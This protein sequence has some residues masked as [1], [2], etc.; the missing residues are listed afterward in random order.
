MYIYL[1]IHIW[2]S[3]LKPLKYILSSLTFIVILFEYIFFLISPVYFSCLSPAPHKITAV[4]KTPHASSSSP[5]NNISLHARYAALIDADNNRLLY[6]KG[7]DIKAPNASTT[8]IITLI[9]ALSICADDYIATTSAY[10][11]SMP[12]VQLNAINGEQFTIKD[13]YFSLM[14]R[15]HNDTAVIIAEN[16]AYYYICNLSDKERNELIYD[17]SFIPDYSNNSSFLKN[18]SKEQS[19]ILVRIFT[20]LMNKKAL[21]AGCTN[22]HFVTPNG[23]DASDENGIH[24][25]TAYDLS[26]MMSYCIKNPDFIEIT[27]SSSY[28]FS[29]LDG[30]RYSVTNANAF[31]SMYDNIISGKTGFTADAGYCYVCAY[32]DE[33]KTFIVALLACGWPNNKS[34]KWTDSKVLLDYA[35]NNFEKQVL[36]DNIKTFNVKVTNGTSGDINVVIDKKYSA[37]VK[38]DDEVKI[39]YNIPDSIMAPVKKNDV[40]GTVTVFINNEAVKQYN[41]I[42]DKDISKCNYARKVSRIIRH[43]LYFLCILIQF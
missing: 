15:S 43:F 35:R 12:D 27:K 5:K 2:R 38:S 18:I 41:I 17:I 13:L 23:L 6:G 42:S 8:K 11:A 4:S 26:V 36:L 25:T 24:Q 40:I 1:K 9:T 39:E 31:L 34:Y 29:N 3:G 10:A 37:Y 30:K 20:D 32:K 33:N 16:A 7:A 19:K 21:E 14:L 28:S 22:T